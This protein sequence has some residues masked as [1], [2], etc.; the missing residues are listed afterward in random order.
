M[1]SGSY[2]R[3]IVDLFQGPTTPIESVPMAA[4]ACKYINDFSAPS[5]GNIKIG[6][7]MN[8][9]DGHFELKPRLINVVRHIPFCGKVLEDANDHLQHFLEICITFTIRGVNQDVVWPRLSHSHYWG[10]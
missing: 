6:L 4:T 3:E 9:G 7:E 5:N 1:S 8:I 10:M 2:I